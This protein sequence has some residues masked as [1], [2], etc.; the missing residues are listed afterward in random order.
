M[1]NMILLVVFGLLQA[2][3]LAQTDQKNLEKYWKF[4]SSFVK[5]FIRIGKEPGES[6]PMIGRGFEKN[7]NYG[8]GGAKGMLYWGDN[9]IWHGHYIGFLVN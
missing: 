2:T 8:P 1:K 4:R 7:P 5:D 3:S 6:L 9:V